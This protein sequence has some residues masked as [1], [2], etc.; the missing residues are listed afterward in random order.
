VIISKVKVKNFRLLRNVELR[1]E[2]SV[3][4][5][6]GRNNCGKTSLSDVLRRFLAE[7]SSFDIEDFSSASYDEFYAALQARITGAGEEDVRALIPH[8]ELRV[9]VTYDVGTT[10]FGPL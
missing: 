6:V 5:V 7:S 1:L 3:T 8:I 9:H 4:V 2:E 10:A